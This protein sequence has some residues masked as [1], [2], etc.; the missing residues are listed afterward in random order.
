MAASQRNPRIITQRSGQAFV[1]YIVVTALAILVLTHGNPS[2]LQL[3]EKNIRDKYRGY[4][5]AVT[6]PVLEPNPPLGL[7]VVADITSCATGGGCDTGD[8][9]KKIATMAG[10]S[11]TFTDGLPSADDIANL[12][13]WD[14][15]KDTL[16]SMVTDFFKGLLSVDT[17]LSMFSI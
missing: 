4:S 7:Q 12:F 9:A 3:L 10:F 6:R 5:F 1:E 17:F 8:I 2:P 14:N 15:F 16:S 13:S 11:D